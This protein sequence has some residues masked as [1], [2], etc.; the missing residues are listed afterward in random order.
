MFNVGDKVV[1]GVNGVM[2]VE[3]IKHSPLKDDTRKYYYLKPVHKTDS[4]SVLTP[5]GNEKVVMRALITSDEARALM[6]SVPHTRALSVDSEKNRRDIYHE[7]VAKCD[8]YVWMSVIRTVRERR[9]KLASL[10]RKPTEA[11]IE[12]EA[13]AKKC[14]FTELS[15]VLGISREEIE[16]S[17]LSQ[18]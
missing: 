3:E 17:V 10:K 4:C 5:V 2:T 15:V 9:K 12:Y 7:E 16:E 1:Y 8:P 14:L 13:I 18:M 11:D 6:G